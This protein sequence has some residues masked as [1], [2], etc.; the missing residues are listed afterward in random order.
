M[1]DIGGESTRPGAAP[2]DDAEE[3][4][5]VVP[6]VSELA[7]RGR[8]GALVGIHPLNRPESLRVGHIIDVTPTAVS[9][10]EVMVGPRG[11]AALL[12]GPGRRNARTHR[13]N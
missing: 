4:R 11:G 9:L 5:R 7:R 3:R 10:N 12:E 6:V 13:T 8:T 2:V 1:L